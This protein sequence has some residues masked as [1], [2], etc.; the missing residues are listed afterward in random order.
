MEQ[1][2]FFGCETALRSRVITK[3]TQRESHEKVDKQVI[4]N[5]ILNEL[6]YGNMTA[7]EIAVVMHR[8]GLVTEP[9][10][11]Q[12]QPRLTELTQ[13]GLVEVIGKRYDSRTDRH[14]AL[15]H[16]VE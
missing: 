16:K 2:N 14:A 9:T 13:E 5:N 8:H 12:V 15:Y 1:M 10:R 3:Q 4:R 11:Q 7:R 6:S